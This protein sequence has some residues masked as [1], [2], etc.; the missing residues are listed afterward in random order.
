MELIIIGVEAAA[1]SDR[2][3]DDRNVI[4]RAVVIGI[5]EGVAAQDESGGGIAVG[6]GVARLRP[7]GK[8]ITVTRIAVELREGIISAVDVD[9]GAD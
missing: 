8:L 3:A 6:E 1:E 4:G 7:S 5:G 2:A 9:V